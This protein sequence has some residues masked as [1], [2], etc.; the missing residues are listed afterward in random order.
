MRVE[1]GAV[2]MIQLDRV[3]RIFEAAGGRAR[4]SVSWNGAAADRLLDERHAALV[5][6]TIAGLERYRWRGDP[7]VSFSE[8]GERGSIDVLGSHRRRHA[9]AV[10]EVKSELGSLEETNRA[11]DAKVR[12]A[13]KI[14][15]ERLGWRPET[16]GR[17]LIV[18]D[19]STNRRIL[20]RHSRTMTN[21]Y[22]GTTN[23]VKRWLRAPDEAF[24]GIWFLSEVPN[25]DRAQ[26]LPEQKS[27]PGD[28]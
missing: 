11:L 23:E 28:F 22:P 13:Q 6:R 3:R 5:E 7:E 4:L 20:R 18:A 26:P 21:L 17:I 1:A 14:A 9:I 10:C 19:S 2:G 24:S 27:R 16:V 12:L 25:R 8:F 15:I